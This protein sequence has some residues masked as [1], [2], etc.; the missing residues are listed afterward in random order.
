MT[1]KKV[2]ASTRR[3]TYGFAGADYPN[4]QTALYVV[5]NKY[6]D[7]KKKHGKNLIETYD[8][9]LVEEENSVYLKL[10]LVVVE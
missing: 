9:A 10:T 8:Q 7:M 5:K 2:N 4:L 3:Y 1:T 6:E